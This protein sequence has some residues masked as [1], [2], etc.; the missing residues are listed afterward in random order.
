MRKPIPIAAAIFA[1]VSTASAVA[2][3]EDRAPRP[4]PQ[5][6]RVAYICTNDEATRSAFEREY[7]QAPVFVTAEEAL[8]AASAGERWSAPRCMTE[9][10]HARLE[11]MRR[12]TAARN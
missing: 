3:Q 7:G 10:Q 5:V 1:V 11:Q 8:A 9:A 6:E 2:A 12:Q 4:E